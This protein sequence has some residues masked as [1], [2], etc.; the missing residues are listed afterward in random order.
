MDQSNSNPLAKYFRAPGVSLRLPSMG[1]F[2]APDNVRFTATGEIN[3]LPMRAADEM[4]LKSPDALMSGMAVEQ[5]LKSC[6]PDLKD[7]R[8]LPSPDVDALL[9]AIRAS[10]YGPEMTVETTCPK[11]EHGNAYS[12]DVTE[13][14]DTVTPLADE[15]P[16]RLN[17]E[18]VAYLRPF[19]FNGSTQIS[20]MV[21]QETRK[22]QLLE[23]DESLSP[24]ERQTQVNTSFKRLNH[25]NIQL[26]ADCVEK[27]V[28]PEATVTEP[29][30]IHQYVHNIGKE[31]FAKL[32]AQLKAINDGG[33]NKTHAVKCVKCEHEWATVVEF[34][35]AS[36]FGQSS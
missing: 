27:V 2:Q 32:E 9:L 36:F 11:C 7:P 30:H 22:M 21:F 5:V 28:T 19:N 20:M 10:T 15:Y 13:I 17:D 35:P 4:L 14:L 18:V 12:F 25:M 8:Q 29:A 24:E 6:V 3:V 34:D 33:I 16:V 23:R 31:V 26:V 1:R